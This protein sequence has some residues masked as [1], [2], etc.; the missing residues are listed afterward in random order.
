MTMGMDE[1]CLQEQF[2]VIQ[3]FRR[4]ACGDD[5]AALKYVTVIGNIFDQIEVVC[6]RDYRLPPSA[7]TYKKVDH[8]A[9]A[10]GIKRGGGLVQ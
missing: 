3:Y 2:T 9:L 6:S 5:A 1:I 4:R 7:T 8:L 10:L